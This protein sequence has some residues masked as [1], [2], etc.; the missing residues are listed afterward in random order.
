MPNTCKSNVKPSFGVVESGAR[1]SNAWEHTQLY[2]I[3]MGNYG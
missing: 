3:T 2:G 1:V